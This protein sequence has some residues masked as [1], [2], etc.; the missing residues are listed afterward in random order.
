MFQG[1]SITSLFLGVGSILLGFSFEIA[2]LLSL[3]HKDI[4]QEE[5]E[6]LIICYMDSV[7]IRCVWNNE[8]Y[9]Q[10][11]NKMKALHGNMAGKKNVFH[12]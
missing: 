9:S 6:W 8:S 12:G 2:K 1:C 5:L 4:I 10:A 11:G 3:L 7:R